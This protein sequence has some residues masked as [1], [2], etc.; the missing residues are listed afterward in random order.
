M[1]KFLIMEKLKI[2]KIQAV[3]DFEE[4]R[5]GNE[6]F[7]NFDSLLEAINY[8]KETSN[9]YLYLKPP[10]INIGFGADSK[11]IGISIRDIK[12]LSEKEVFETYETKYG[13]QISNLRN[14]K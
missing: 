7:E 3:K 11:P 12:K 10:L 9:G 8:I 14:Q 1:V 6:K 13:E 5:N 4:M 2:V